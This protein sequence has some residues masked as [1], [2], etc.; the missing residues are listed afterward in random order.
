MEEELRIPVTTAPVS[1]PRI[2]LEVRRGSSVLRVSPAA[3]LQPVRKLIQPV[4]K[5]REATEKA[6]RQNEPVRMG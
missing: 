1:A 3:L 4:Q 5:E 2:R 6:Q